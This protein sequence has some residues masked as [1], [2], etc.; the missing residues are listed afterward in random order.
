[1]Q[2][3][4]RQRQIRRSGILCD[5]ASVLR[6]MEPALDGTLS[7]EEICSKITDRTKIV[8]IGYVSNVLGVTNPV[9]KIAEEAHRHGAVC[10]VDGAQSTPHIPVNVQEIGCD[11]YAFSGHKLMAPMGIGC[12]YGRMELL[13]EM[14]PFLTGGISSEAVRSDVLRAPQCAQYPE[15]MPHHADGSPRY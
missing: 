9:K 3:R 11:F 7:E 1:M 6:A 4:H 5:N 8:S 2:I 10:V 15:R 14:P 13:N 12:L